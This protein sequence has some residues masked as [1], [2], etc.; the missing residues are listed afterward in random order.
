MIISGCRVD[1]FPTAEE[2][3]DIGVEEECLGGEELTSPGGLYIMGILPLKIFFRQ[4]H[5]DG[6]H[7]LVEPAIVE[8]HGLLGVEAGF[9]GQVIPADRKPA[10]PVIWS[11]VVL[12]RCA[13]W[14]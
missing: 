7:G 1:L 10:A 9:D 8:A 5:F 11:P 2:D 4:P 14:A 3:G 13:N 12:S 6:G